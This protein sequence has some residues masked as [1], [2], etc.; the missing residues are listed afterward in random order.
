MCRRIVGEQPVVAVEH[1]L[2]VPLCP[3]VTL[4]VISIREPGAMEQ[5]AVSL[6]GAD[7]AMYRAKHEG[8]NRVISAS[9]TLTH[10]VA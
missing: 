9:E 6:R 2:L 1:T 5:L 8:R 7:A 3:N 4:G 10:A